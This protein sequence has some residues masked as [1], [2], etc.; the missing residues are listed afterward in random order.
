MQQ[1][2]RREECWGEAVVS[3]KMEGE[4]HARLHEL[5]AAQVEHELREEGHVVVQAEALGVVLAVVPKPVRTRPASPSLSAV[6]FWLRLCSIL[7]GNHSNRKP[8]VS[9]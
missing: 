6:S 9:A 1:C 3:A 8:K 5:R 7:G 4:L 2:C